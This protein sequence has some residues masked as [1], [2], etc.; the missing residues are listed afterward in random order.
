M[1]AAARA[2]KPALLGVI[3]EEH[4]RQWMIHHSGAAEDSI[5]YIRKVGE[6]EGLPYV[7]EFAFG[8]RE[9]DDAGRRLLTG[10]N[11]S[12]TLENPLPELRSLLQT[13]RVDPHDPVTVVVHIAKPQ[14]R[15]TERGKGAVAL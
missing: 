15:F 2:P 7:L 1:Q 5:R 6:D 4:L 12:A 3:G 10:L 8:V 13:M 14:F 11:W 9:D